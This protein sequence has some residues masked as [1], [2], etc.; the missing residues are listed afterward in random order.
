MN[1]AYAE[2]FKGG[3][4]I[5]SGDLNA[6]GIPEIYTVPISSGGPQVRSF[7]AYTDPVGG[8]FAFNPLN[9]NGLSIAVWNP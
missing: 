1:S 8:F 9:R 4:D 2:A 7:S 3:V 6:D 5:V